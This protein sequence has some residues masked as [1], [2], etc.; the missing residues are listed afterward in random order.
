MNI[1]K[2]ARGTIL[3]WIFTLLAGC[4]GGGGGGESGLTQPE[5]IEV[6]IAA[7]RTTLPA[8]TLD[9]EPTLGS[10]FTTSVTVTVQRADGSPIANGTSVQL[11]LAPV[12]GTGG[13]SKLDDP[14]TADVNEFLQL[15]GTLFTETASGQAQFFFTSFNRPGSATL[16]ATVQDPNNG[17][18]V[19]ATLEISVVAGAG[20][21]LPASISIEPP[22]NPLYIKGINASDTALLT[23]LL[24][25]GSGLL[26]PDPVAGASNLQVEILPGSPGGG[27]LLEGNDAG[28]QPVTGT[29]IRVRT[30]GG[31]G[32]VNL[33]S[34]SEQ[35]IAVVRVTA[36]RAD[37]N[38]DNGISTPIS[39]DI[40]LPISDGVLASLVFA[41]TLVVNANATTV[42]DGV[43]ALPDGT[44][45]L[46]VSA[47]ARDALGQPVLPGTPIVFGL[48]DFPTTKPAAAACGL[49]LLNV[50]TD[51]DP[52]EGG[53]AFR[54]AGG[55]F[56][57]DGAV[58]GDLLL[59][60]VAG[61][62][63]ETGG[64]R[65][66]QV[67][68]NQNLTIRSTG[69]SPFDAAFNDLDGLNPGPVASYIIGRPTKANIASPAFADANG[70]ASTVMNYPTIYINDPVALVAQGL[71][72]GGKTVGTVLETVFQAPGPATLAVE[73]TQ[74]D[75]TFTCLDADT[76]G[77]DD[78]PETPEDESPPDGFCDAPVTGL[79]QSALFSLNDELGNPLPNVK[80][81]GSVSGT[82]DIVTGNLSCCTDANGRCSVTFTVEPCDSSD[83]PGACS[84]EANISWIGALA[85]AATGIT[86]AI[87]VQE[88]APAPVPEP[89]PEPAAGGGL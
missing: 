72:A 47:L 11:S 64:R 22:S 21:G 9:Q 80:I 60:E 83:T 32:A 79:P 12:T 1:I 45:N 56:L 62:A 81:Q 66:A 31:I 6:F 67:T 39:D 13:I 18:E 50:G 78:D 82:A 76:A 84:L 3:L 85:T 20:T 43:T 65:I 49:D 15:F 46:I 57:I 7:E 26:V 68:T 30:L 2:L 27:L 28:G 89:E 61:N 63:L 40:Q 48:V 86:S 16:T 37:N 87:E 4:G 51:G 59:F 70:I 14:A 42:V 25:D 23:I 36:D 69:V 34:G 88:V 73:P 24:A 33:L 35:G 10:P 8:N 5:L 54:S 38:V 77:V 52:T 75:V 41:P 55:Q 74:I 58:A 19:S 44:Y 17:Q 29:L 53:V 71:G